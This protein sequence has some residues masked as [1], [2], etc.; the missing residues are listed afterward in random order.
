MPHLFIMVDTI[1]SHLEQPKTYARISFID[2]TS[3]FNTVQINLVL[4]CLIDLGVN[5][6]LILLDYGLF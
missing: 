2:Y 1:I 5:E 4:S 6:A 3:V